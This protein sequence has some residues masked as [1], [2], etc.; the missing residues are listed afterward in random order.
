MSKAET[1]LDQIKVL[2]IGQ[3]KNINVVKKP[4]QENKIT[5]QKDIVE[6][7]F[8]AESIFMMKEISTMPLLGRFLTRRR[9]REQ[10]VIYVYGKQHCEKLKVPERAQKPLPQ[11]NPGQTDPEQP[12]QEQKALVEIP[13]LFEPLTN[14]ERE[15]IVKRAIAKALKHFK[16]ISNLGLVVIVVL[17]IVNLV[18]TLMHARGMI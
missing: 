6:P 11:L 10:C 4:I 7:F 17:L 2:L 3:N 1:E 18:I 16:P 12:E 15:D 13:D 14:V 9:K 5:I 8:D